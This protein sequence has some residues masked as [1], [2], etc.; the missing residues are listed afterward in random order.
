MGGVVSIVCMLVFTSPVPDSTGAAETVQPT[1]ISQADSTLSDASEKEI[2]ELLRIDQSRKLLEQGL[3]EEAHQE[4]SKSFTTNWGKDI[5]TLIVRAWALFQTE[6][7]EELLKVL[8][9]EEH[10]NE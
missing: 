3:A 2:E 8:P 5:S 10:D 1:P 6:R 9:N 7:F 4:L